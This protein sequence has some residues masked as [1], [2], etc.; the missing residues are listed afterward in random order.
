MGKTR[1]QVSAGENP[2]LQLGQAPGREVWG[3]GRGVESPLRGFREQGQDQERQARVAGT[4]SSGSPHSQ[5]HANA[6]GQP[7]RPLPPD[8]SL[9]SPGC[10]PAPMT[11][12]RFGGAQ[13]RTPL[14]RLLPSVPTARASEH[15]TP[16]SQKA[17]TQP[18]YGVVPL[19]HLPRLGAGLCMMLGVQAK[20]K[21]ILYTWGTWGPSVRLRLRS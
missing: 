17:T 18:Y 1:T 16:K 10:R 7:S 4:K 8:T 6:G 5:G 19:V 11:A 20:N 3:S 14:S 15:R 21:V 9:A 13:D 12:A 2:H